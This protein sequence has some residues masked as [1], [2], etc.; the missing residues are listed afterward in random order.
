[1]A[2]L[3]V[4]LVCVACQFLM[5]SAHC[6]ECS[7]CQLSNVTFNYSSIVPRGGTGPADE[8]SHYQCAHPTSLVIVN[9][10]QTV[11]A[12]LL[13]FEI[14]QLIPPSDQTHRFHL[15]ITQAVKIYWLGYDGTEIM[16]HR[17]RSQSNI[18]HSTCEG[19][20]WLIKSLREVLNCEC[21]RSHHLRTSTIYEQNTSK[22]EVILQT[23]VFTTLKQTK[24]LSL[25]K[26]GCPLWLCR[27]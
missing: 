27:R 19:H 5:N 3:A 7:Y 8:H 2:R 9:H 10:L 4:A 20:V 25:C 17:L 14:C 15:V 6:P 13:P 21:I 24:R 1:M 16:L 11:V 18:T 22:N 12:T 23:L 26:R